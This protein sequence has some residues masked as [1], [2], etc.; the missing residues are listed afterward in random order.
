MSTQSVT[1]TESAFTQ[2]VA[3]GKN[4]LVETPSGARA[5]AVFSTSQPTKDAIGHEVT[6]DKPLARLGVTG[7]LWMRALLPYG[8]SIT[9][10][11]SKED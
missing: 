3:A 9:A 11:V 4:F 8:G 1:I 6:S 7:A 2:V 10:I 5:I